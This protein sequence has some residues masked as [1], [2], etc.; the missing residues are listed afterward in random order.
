MKTTFT[1]NFI[2]IILFIISIEASAQINNTEFQINYTPEQIDVCQTTSNSEITILAK[3][4]GLSDFEITIGL[5][6]GVLYESGSITVTAAPTGYMV[7][8]LNISDLS[9]PV[10]SISNGNSWGAGDEVAI[11]ITRSGNCDAV[12]HSLNAGTFKEEVFIRYKDGG[13]SKTDMDTDPAINSYQVN[14]GVLS[15]LPV[16]PVFSTVGTF[17]TRDVI[18]RQGGFGCL[19]TYEHYVVVSRELIN[20]KF[21]FDGAL[22]SPSSILPNGSGT[23]DTM[24]YLIDMAATPFNTVGNANGCFD[25][26]EEM[27]FVETF[28]VGGCNAS[29]FHHSNWGC[30]NDICLAAVPQNG[31]VNITNGVPDVKITVLSNPRLELCDTINY[32][33]L[34]TNQGIETTPPGGAIATDLAI[35]FGLGSNNTPISTPTNSTTWGSIQYNT[36]FWGNFKLNGIPVVDSSLYSSN[37]SWGAAS[38]IAPDFYTSDPD[39]SGGLKDIDGDGFF[40]DL[41]T[42]DSIIVS[43]DYWIKPRTFA[44]TADPSRNYIGWYHNFFDVNWENQCGAPSAPRRVDLNYSAIMKHRFIISEFSGPLDIADGDTFTVDFLPSFGSYGANS[45]LCNGQA[46]MNSASSDWT[47]TIDLPPG[48]S[49]GPNP[50]TNPAHANLNPSIVQVGNQVIY[51][52][53]RYTFTNFPIQLQFDCATSLGGSVVIPV[54]SNYTCSDDNGNVCWTEDIHCYELIVRTHC[55]L[56]CTG[57]VTKGFDAKRATAGW[58]DAT[59]TTHVNLDDPGYNLDYYLPHDT[60]NV[61]SGAVMSDTAVT[62]LFFKMTYSNTA[63]GIDQIQLI[64]AEIEIFDISSGTN[65]TFPISNLPT[66]MTESANNFSL[67][68][69]LSSFNGMVNSTY[70]YGGDLSAPGIYSNDSIKIS[71]NF[72]VADD[73]NEITQYQLT[74]FTG[75]FYT[76]DPAGDPIVCDVYSDR[77]TF[78]KVQLRV[79]NNVNLDFFGCEEIIA[80]FY[81]AQISSSAD[82]YPNEYRPSY[83]LDSFKI[84]IPPTLTFT[85]TLHIRNVIMGQINDITSYRFDGNDLWIYPPP[86]WLDNDK[87]TTNW[88]RIDAGFVATCSQPE[89]M[90]IFH[91]FHGTRYFYHPNSSVHEPVISGNN[92]TK[93]DYFAPQFSLQ[94]NNPNQS[95]VREEVSWDMEVCNTTSFA[96]VDYNWLNIEN[97]PNVSVTSITEVLNGVETTLPYLLGTDGIFVQIGA[98]NNIE[99]KTIRINANYSDCGV[100]TIEVGHNWDCTE[101]PA[102]LADDDT[103]C[104]IVETLTITPQPSQ[105]QMSILDQ[106]NIISLCSLL[107]YELEI[108]S[109][110]LADIVDPTFSILFNNAPGFTVNSTS[111]EYPAGSGNIEVLSPTVSQTSLMYDLNDHSLIT[112]NPGINGTITATDPNDRKVLV[113]IELITDCDFVSGSSLRFQVGA[114]QPCGVPA[115]GDQSILISDNLE[116]PQALDLYDANVSITTNALSTVCNT[117]SNVDVQI[118]ITGGATSGAD[119]SF[120][121][122]P[123]GVSFDTGTFNCVPTAGVFC[124]TYTVSTINGQEVLVMAI[125]SGMNSGD[126]LDFSFEV[127]ADSMFVY[128]DSIV[129]LNTTELNNIACGSTFC[130]SISAQTGFGTGI[131]DIDFPL[132]SVGSM[133]AAV[134]CFGSN[135]GSATVVANGGTA[136][137][138]YFWNNGA[139]TSTVT[140]VSEGTYT[141]VITDAKGCVS[142]SSAYVSS[143]ADINISFTQTDLSCNGYTDGTISAASS[144]G[145]SGYNYTWSTGATTSSISGIG[146]GTYVVSVTDANGCLKTSST[147]ILEP[148]VLGCNMN[149]VNATCFGSYNGSASATT[150]GGTPGYSYLWDGGAFNQTTQTAVGLGAGTYDLTI[151]DSQGCLSQC[152]VTINEPPQLKVFVNSMDVSCVGFSD[153]S[154]ALNAAGGSPGYSYQWGASAGGQTTATIA[155][156]SAGNYEATITDDA[157]CTAIVYVLI[158]TE[159]CDPCALDV[160]AVLSADPSNPLGT[161]DCDGDGVANA[162]E[163]TDGTDPKNECDFLVGSITLPVT[164]DQSGCSNLC[165]DLSPIMTILPGNIAGVS[166]VAVA[167][168]VVEV[169]DVDTDGGVIIVRIPSDPRFVFVWDISLSNAALV[170]VNNTFWNYLGN[171]GFVHTWTYNGP[172]GVI[173]AGLRASFGFEAI[174]DPQAT[175]GQTTITATIVPTSGGE[176]K[177]T[178]NT[179]SERLVYFK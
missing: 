69:D 116:I 176:C 10:F 71:A 141:V 155:N 56:P 91:E 147:T 14:Y 22:L 137:Y 179:D 150:T 81:F 121:Y 58:T 90:A 48:V 18:V 2:V 95:G 78:E 114:N 162:N 149:V 148:A 89:N 59:M 178:N 67:T 146:N 42:G 20:Y 37:V 55:P 9:N 142:T 169:N 107:T 96:D 170:Q 119:S 101:Y 51:E 1:S 76:L 74:N 103:T 41:A 15:I 43:F 26:G 66:P 102:S 19:S 123:S 45:P 57:P 144:G 23:A 38:F 111:F 145:T 108:N 84:E 61:C 70:L 130:N 113:T 47:V 17:E 32:K 159:N 93:L 124:P 134:S 171:N 168:E 85:G 136:P 122:L 72:V 126:I 172:G 35:I 161:I 53:D 73:F 83:R 132:S 77:A 30:N 75:S 44:C 8:E 98:I 173:P 94:A 68:F 115:I 140:G 34:I 164:A 100:Q 79:A 163:C 31:V 80:P 39:G 131:L 27:L 128:G 153:G 65:Y 11:T 118:F 49:L 160:C 166:G 16:A 106:P 104:Y 82:V 88:A 120:L 105:V 3:D 127:S 135:D 33:I 92:G 133:S 4:I 109:A 158:E 24:F 143:P 138:S 165:P 60:M 154:I 156:L 40:D 117:S 50:Q 167:V 110:Q 174:Y 52:V 12:D 62:D 125:P 29:S 99:C 152:A 139:N 6:P 36:R 87:I 86:G 7:T 175:D 13:V 157:G 112:A 5:P 54:T 28:T 25:N 46:A 151:T 177:L 21:Y 129:I 63:S 64:D 97:N